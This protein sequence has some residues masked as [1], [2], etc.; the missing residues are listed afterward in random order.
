MSKFKYRRVLRL[1]IVAY[2]KKCRKI[3]LENQ[4][5][6][7]GYEH[8]TKLEKMVKQLKD[9]NAEYPIKIEKDLVEE[10]SKIISDLELI[11]N[12]K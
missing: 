7:F 12:Q 9:V 10:A 11:F 5:S 6:E 3:I 1:Q 8:L 2:M 4:K